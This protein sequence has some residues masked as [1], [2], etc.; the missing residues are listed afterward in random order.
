VVNP[1]IVLI[2][3]F[4]NITSTQTN[5]NY[6]P[7]YFSHWAKEEQMINIFISRAKVAGRITL[8]VSFQQIIFSKGS[9][10]FQ[11]PKENFDPMRDLG[12]PDRFIS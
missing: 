8:L 3:V 7:D 12:F 2:D 5:S 11:Q 9:F 1:V 10:I 4:R 6:S